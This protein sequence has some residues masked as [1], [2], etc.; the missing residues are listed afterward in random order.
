ME[1]SLEELIDIINK[2]LEKGY[3]VDEKANLPGANPL[4]P[5]Y[6]DGADMMA[7][8]LKDWFAWYFE[9]GEKL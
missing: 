1:F 8:Y 5:A 2:R 4:S 6:N 3:I 7:K 9:T